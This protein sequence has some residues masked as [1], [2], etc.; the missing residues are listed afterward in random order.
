M[1]IFQGEIDGYNVP[2]LEIKEYRNIMDNVY[3]DE[4]IYRYPDLE[5]S[6]HWSVPNPHGTV[7]MVPI[8]MSLL[9]SAAI[10]CNLGSIKILGK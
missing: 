8:G 2:P 10:A 9:E 6:A 7:G 4:R 1:K 3:L 5:N